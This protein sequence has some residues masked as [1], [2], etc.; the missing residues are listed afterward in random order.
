MHQRYQA[1]LSGSPGPLP[2]DFSDVFPRLVMLAKEKPKIRNMRLNKFHP[3]SMYPPLNLTLYR[4][5]TFSVLMNVCTPTCDPFAKAASFFGCYTLPRELGAGHRP[6]EPWLGDIVSLEMR[7]GAYIKGPERTDLSKRHPA[8]EAHKFFLTVEDEAHAPGVADTLKLVLSHLKVYAGSKSV[9]TNPQRWVT[10]VI[11]CP[12]SVL[13]NYIELVRLFC[14]MMRFM[15]LLTV[16]LAVPSRPAP[17]SS[18]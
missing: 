6:D 9:T 4:P 12:A 18:N 2:T 1:V 14:C 16:C 7:P 3:L 13:E 17:V 5:I 8:K 11:R 15:R 10:L